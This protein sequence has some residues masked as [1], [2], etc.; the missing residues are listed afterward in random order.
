[1]EYIKQG[2]NSATMQSFNFVNHFKLKSKINFNEPLIIFGV[3]NKIDGNIIKKCKSHIT[4][5]WC[6]VDSYNQ[7][8]Q[9][10]LKFIAS[11]PNIRHIT[12]LNFVPSNLKKIGIHCEI[13]PP[14]RSFY[15]KNNFNPIKKGNKIFSYMPTHNRKKVKL[16]P[17]ILNYYGM[18]II[19]ELK[20]KKDLL[21]LNPTTNG[22]IDLQKWKKE[23]GIN[24]YK[25]C[26]IG[27]GLSPG[28]GGAGGVIEMGLCGLKVISNVING[29]HVLQW[30][31]IE[32][33]KNYIIDER[34]T[35]GE[36]DSSLSEKVLEY[37]VDDKDWLKIK[38]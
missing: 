23:V 28:G 15:E 38:K 13:I 8:N 20:V 18:N 3:Y 7:F 21:L 25:E 1:M 9:I 26:F 14:I 34:K 30:S 22:V 31:S 10:P 17:A 36:K 32:D 12:C 5:V 11:H 6:G 33:I 35:I 29:P 24:F 27:L 4:I 19:Q 16:S 2:Y 37:L